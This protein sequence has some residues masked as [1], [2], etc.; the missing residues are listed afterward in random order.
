M[1][2]CWN[3]L[4]QVEASVEANTFTMVAI[5]SIIFDALVREAVYAHPRFRVSRT[6]LTPGDFPS[7]FLSVASNF[8]LSAHTKEDNLN[9]LFLTCDE[10]MPE[11]I[12]AKHKYDDARKQQMSQRVEEAKMNEEIAQA[13]VGS[14]TENPLHAQQDFM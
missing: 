2:I 14:S 6:Y 9:T 10:L 12:E 8:W 13:V 11:Q 7:Q 5:C 4:K 1:L 3:S